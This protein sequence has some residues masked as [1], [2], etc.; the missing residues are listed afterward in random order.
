MFF[1]QAFELLWKVF[2]RCGILHDNV[3]VATLMLYP[4]A[5]ASG[6]A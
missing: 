3:P 2:I 6:I 1:L 5:V 4:Q